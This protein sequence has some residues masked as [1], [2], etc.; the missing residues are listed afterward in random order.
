MDDLCADFG[1]S[2]SFLR[3]WDERLARLRVQAVDAIGES[4]AVAASERGRG[5]RPAE[6][7]T[8]ITALASAA[9]A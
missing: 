4:E 9:F 3:E 8:R 6:R 1:I 5:L 7:I 2:G